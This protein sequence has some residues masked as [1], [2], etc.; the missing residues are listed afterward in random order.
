MGIPKVP[1]KITSSPERCSNG[2]YCDF[3]QDHGLDTEQC[4]ELWKEIE[5]G[6]CQGL[7]KDFITQQ[8]DYRQD[9]EKKGER[10]YRH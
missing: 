6:I 9:N 1:A 3:Y 10:E 2:K 5:N 7:L 8:V 4:I